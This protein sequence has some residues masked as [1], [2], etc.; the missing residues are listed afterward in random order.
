MATI[1]AISV[2][3][4]GL[5]I[6]ALWDSLDTL[7]QT[8]KILGC[9]IIVVGVAVWVVSERVETLQAAADTEE[10]REH[11]QKVRSLEQRVKS[12]T[13]LLSPAAR[14]QL[15]ADLRQLPEGEFRLS[16]N[17]NTPESREFG[18]TVFAAMEEA[19]CNVGRT[20]AHMLVD[21]QRPIS[22]IVIVHPDDRPTPLA[23]ALYEAFSA[24]GIGGVRLEGWRDKVFSGVNAE[25]YVG[26]RVDA[27][28]DDLRASDEK[29]ADKL[30]SRA[31]ILTPEARKVL[32]SRFA[33]L[34]PKSVS[35]IAIDENAESREF[36]EIIQGLLEESGS[37]SGWATVDRSMMGLVSPGRVVA[38]SQAGDGSLPIA[39]ALAEALTE[40]GI[41]DVT[42][43]PRAS[44]GFSSSETVQLIIKPK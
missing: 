40:A 14:R 29:L 34:P 12:R 18:D 17:S 27:P 19:G 38:Q 28:L 10:A 5:L 39:N 44:T 26:P 43:E 9:L 24:T 42:V 41:P 2:I 1:I 16:T 11:R 22:G 21:I 31:D 3:V 15:V 32:A 25:V 6:Y 36:R 30:A 13:E 8:N 23:K 37:L 35:I 33:K 7:K 4:I 20:H